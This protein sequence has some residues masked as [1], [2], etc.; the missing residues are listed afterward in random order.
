MTDRDIIERL[1]EDAAVT[2]SSASAWL[3]R[4]AA[5]EIER[6]NEIVRQS[7]AE[8]LTALV[9][10]RDRL[11]AALEEITRLDTCVQSPL[12]PLHGMGIGL[13]HDQAARI[14]RQAL[15]HPA[16]HA[17]NDDPAPEPTGAE[18]ASA[19]PLAAEVN[20][21]PPR[22]RQYVHDL[23]ANADPAGDKARLLN[24]EENVRAVGIENERLRAAALAAQALARTAHADPRLNSP[25]DELVSERALCALESALDAAGMGMTDAEADA[26]P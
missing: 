17:G 8:S 5:D 21:L 12:G 10:E 24:L 20:A 25:D 16:S 9:E 6:L 18:G 14:A 11:R 2:A 15:D 1:Y 19:S 7:E 23:V 3:E 13:G 4:E 22:M 26:A